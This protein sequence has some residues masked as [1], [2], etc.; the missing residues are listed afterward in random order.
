M[1]NIDGDMGLIRALRWGIRDN[2]FK[3][4]IWFILEGEGCSW[5]LQSRRLN[6]I[7]KMTMPL[8][9]ICEDN[10]DISRQNHQQRPG[11]L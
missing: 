5:M 3:K 7:T 1:H 4:A 8:L 10:S 11:R 6:P 9:L 2:G